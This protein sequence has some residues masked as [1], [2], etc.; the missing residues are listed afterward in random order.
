MV[1]ALVGTVIA[2]IATGA[3]ALMADI[4]AFSPKA[5]PRVLTSYEKT[6]VNRVYVEKL[7][8]VEP[9]VA[10]WLKQQE[11]DFPKAKARSIETQ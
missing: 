3:L 2:L 7:S 11:V 5:T 4:F 9:K 8:N 6:L 10:E 1:E